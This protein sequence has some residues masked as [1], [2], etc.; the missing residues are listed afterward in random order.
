MKKLVAILAAVL[1]SSSV[2]SSALAHQDQSFLNRASSGIFEENYDLFKLSPAYLPGFEK[3]AFWGQLSNLYNTSDRLVN[4]TN[5]NYYL[6]GGHMDVMGMGRA[7][8]MSDW[9]S[10]STP[11]NTDTW[12]SGAGFN[13]FGERTIVRYRDRDDDEIIDF[14]E[15]TYGRAERT[16]NRYT[17][18]IYAAY[19]MGGIA[20]F[21]LGAGIRANWN[22]YAPTY[23]PY[24]PSSR[25]S[26]DEFGYE[27]ELDLLTNQLIY[28]YDTEGTGSLTYGANDWFLILSGRSQ[29][30]MP[31]TDVVFNVGPV[32]LGRDNTLEWNWMETIDNAPSDPNII[33]ES[34]RERSE[35]G[36]EEGYGTQ[37]YPG[38]GM[39]FFGTV[40]MDMK[41]SF[42]GGGQLNNR[43][44]TDLGFYTA[45]GTLDED[46]AKKTTIDRNYYRATLVSGFLQTRNDVQTWEDTWEGTFGTTSMVAKVRALWENEGWDYGMG[47]GLESTS[48]ETETT[49]VDNYNRNIR[50]VV[51][52]TDNTNDSTAVTTSSDTRETKTKNVINAFSL[53]V[54]IQ[55][56]FLKNFSIQLSAEHQIALMQNDSSLVE[57]ARD[58]QTTVTTTDDGVVSVNVIGDSTNITAADSYSS[59]QATQSTHFAY[60][61]TWWPFEQV[62]VDFTGLTNITQLSNYEISISLYY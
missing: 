30:L 53:P 36:M 24:A 4:N 49:W 2:V 61:V 33:S 18:D 1:I 19:G 42:T 29:N 57:K 56:H 46:K 58:L 37:Y 62:R 59:Y 55:M 28:T 20:G 16:T 11:Q 38:G 35:E 44:I 51:N 48:Y 39:G 17:N 41:T 12:N 7:G 45:G 10:Y 40:R 15:E 6:A 43:L 9:Y 3:N 50:T 47:I 25:N 60:G 32:L 52:D 21:D 5:S 27:R 26:F 8:I 34:L 22:S 31:N 14:R 54:A 23:N 13:G